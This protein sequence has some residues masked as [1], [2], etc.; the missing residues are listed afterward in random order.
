MQ[1]PH[2]LQSSGNIDVIIPE[3]SYYTVKAEGQKA[4]TSFSTGLHARL[5][6]DHQASPRNESHDSWRVVSTSG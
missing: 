3:L 4:F 2:F 6:G 5:R 1:L